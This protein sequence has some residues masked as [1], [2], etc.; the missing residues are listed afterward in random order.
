MRAGVSSNLMMPATRSASNSR[1]LSDL[2]I[3]SGDRFKSTMTPILVGK[4]S[5]VLASKL[6]AQY[7]TLE[8]T[9]SCS[10]MGLVGQAR[11]GAI[12]KTRLWFYFYPL[13]LNRFVDANKLRLSVELNEMR[14]PASD[15]RSIA[16]ERRQISL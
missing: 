8:Q 12:F 4:I 1:H 16:F 9:T 13:K 14:P 15:C 10:T 3:C 7:L 5:N 6:G 2:Y 11:R